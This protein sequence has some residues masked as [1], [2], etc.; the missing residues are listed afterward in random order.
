MRYRTL[1]CRFQHFQRSQKAIRWFTNKTRRREKND[2]REASHRCMPSSKSLH[3]SV[4][5]G[6]ATCTCRHRIV[7]EDAPYLCSSARRSG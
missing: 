1:R 3:F 6:M 4:A 2:P 5:W 7:L